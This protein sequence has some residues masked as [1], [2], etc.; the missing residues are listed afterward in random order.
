MGGE[1]RTGHKA[2]KKEGGA[3]NL[4]VSFIHG[5]MRRTLTRTA[6]VEKEEESDSGA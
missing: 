3:R 4:G 5:R 2:S 1:G 6:G